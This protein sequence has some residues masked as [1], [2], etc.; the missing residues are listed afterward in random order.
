MKL[1]LFIFASCLI[2]FEIAIFCSI[3]FS[4]GLSRSL[5]GLKLLKNM[6]LAPPTHWSSIIP[7]NLINFGLD[8]MNSIENMKKIVFSGFSSLKD[9]YFSFLKAAILPTTRKIAPQIVKF[10]FLVKFFETFSPI[11]AVFRPDHLIPITIFALGT[12]YIIGELIEA[13]HQLKLNIGAGAGFLNHFLERGS[14][15]TWLIKNTTTV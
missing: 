8:F 15:I 4:D 7:D 14:P 12:V 11:L 10:T 6:K 1:K 3:Y 5:E 9:S 13:Q 2:T